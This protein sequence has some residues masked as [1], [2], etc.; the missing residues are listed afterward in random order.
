MRDDKTSAGH[1]D[2]IS[3]RAGRLEA[4]RRGRQRSRRAMSVGAA[5]LVVGLVGALAVFALAPVR[6]S[7]S[8]EATLLPPTSPSTAVSTTTRPRAVAVDPTTA[9]ENAKPGTD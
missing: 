9:Q 1:S 7:P 3:S 8:A 2:G 5:V 4:A 6:R